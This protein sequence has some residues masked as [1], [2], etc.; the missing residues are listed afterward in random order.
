MGVH[1]GASALSGTASVQTGARASIDDSAS[2]NLKLRHPEDN[3][4]SGWTPHFEKLDTEISASIHGSVKAWAELGITIKAEAFGKWGYQA[5]LDAQLPYFE[6]NLNATYN[7]AGVCGTEKTAGVQL[8]ANVGIN[9]NLNAGEVNEA[10]KFQKDLFETSWP[11]FSTCVGFGGD[12][13]QTGVVSVPSLGGPETVGAGGDAVPTVAETTAV[14]TDVHT[15]VAT[16]DIVPE[17]TMPVPVV[18][19]TAVTTI[20]PVVPPPEPPTTSI[21]ISS[22]LERTIEPVSTS[23][24]NT[25]SLVPEQN[26][27]S[28]VHEATLSSSPIAPESTSAQYHI[29]TTPAQ[30]YRHGYEEYPQPPVYAFSSST[31][32]RATYTTA[33][34]SVQEYQG[35]PQPPSYVHRWTT[36]QSAHPVKTPCASTLLPR[37]KREHAALNLS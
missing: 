28:A 3:G 6:A 25:S 12:V 4:I 8:D 31:M 23:L 17:P 15:P 37:L 13:A 24:T 27:T 22:S 29:A 2:I 34:E 18:T 36:V 16:T 11:L 14:L 7:E 10:P 35:A 19:P 1:L 33:T 30:G 32:P 26:D 21:L 9:I 5:S 20:V